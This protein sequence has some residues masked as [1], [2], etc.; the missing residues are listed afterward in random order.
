MPE[1]NV[2]NKQG[3]SVIVCCFNSEQRLPETLKH[4]ATQRCQTDWEVIVVD[5]NS[6]DNTAE[7]ARKEWDQYPV[8]NANLKIVAELRPGLNFARERGV[9]EAKYE[10]IL[11]CDDDNWLQND[12]LSIGYQLISKDQSIGAVGGECLPTKEEQISLPEWFE[13]FKNNY[14]V[15]KQA[16][17]SGDITARGYLWGAGLITSK[18][19]FNACI[20]AEFPYLLTDRKGNLLT[21]GG[22][23][24]LC[25]RIIL[26]GY[27]LY[28]DE[29][30]KLRHFIPANRLSREY[31]EKL[32][33][34]INTAHS[35]LSKYY[36]LIYIRSLNNR[37]KLINT[38]KCL[39]KILL[40]PV[41]KKWNI[42]QQ[43]QLLFFYTGIDAGVDNSLKM[44]KKFSRGA[45]GA[46]R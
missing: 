22:D 42:E 3:I 23:T 17:Y 2:H 45:T 5:N 15:G 32:L 41:V 12:F 11:F 43:K 30:L 19:I 25:S 35:E 26:L 6:L 9:Q 7:T 20:N 10:Y 14:A 44:L 4:L 16:N 34:G 8:S 13:N 29:R 27:K 37:Q 46:H 33:E 31:F 24:E 1:I 28:Y 36:N 21:S 38:F 40:N 18:T 39:A